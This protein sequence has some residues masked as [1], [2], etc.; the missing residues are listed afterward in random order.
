MISSLFN[1]NRQKSYAAFL[2]IASRDKACVN[3]IV[4]LGAKLMSKQKMHHHFFGDHSWLATAQALVTYALG[5][6]DPQDKITSQECLSIF[7]LFEKRIANRMPVEYI[8]E[9]AQYCGHSFYV[10]ESVLVPRSIMNARF[11][12]FLNR[13]SWENYRVLDLCTGSG[14][15]G[16]S[17]A[18]MNSRIQVDLADI[19]LEALDVAQA[20][21]EKHGL[22]KRVRC[23][24]SDC[25]ENIYGQY[26]LIITNPPYVSIEEYVQTPEEFKKEPKIAL[27]SGVEGLDVVHVILSEAKNY[28]NPK[29]VLIAE[30]GPPA[31]K[32][33]K[34]HYPKV[35]FKW[36]KY[37][38]A[39][40]RISWFSSPGVFLCHKEDLQGIQSGVNSRV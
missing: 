37:K 15:I 30:V 22:Q 7:A 19:S 2:K 35:R 3:D 23:I 14:C 1:S 29:G 39:N 24:Q 31:A 6:K 34:K 27:E 28:L 26:D 13:I 20:N 5:E 12:E 18:L 16:I 25:F 33:L 4:R 10:N 17:L 32:R 11:Q 40:G 8:L 38:R 21:I 9:Q 36:F